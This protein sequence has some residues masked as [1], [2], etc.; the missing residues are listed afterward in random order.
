MI[1]FTAATYTATFLNICYQL[2]GE[3]ITKLKTTILQ[4]RF[5]V[6]SLVSPPSSTAKLLSFY[7][8]IYFKRVLLGSR[9]WPANSKLG[10]PPRRGEY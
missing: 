5:E 3:T 7:L 1:I 10:C 9:G 6:R 2:Q 4:T 8:F